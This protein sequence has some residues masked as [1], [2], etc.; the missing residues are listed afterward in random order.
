MQVSAV[1]SLAPSTLSHLP[2]EPE[3]KCGPGALPGFK[4]IKVSTLPSLTPSTL[5][6]L[7][8]E[9]ERKCGPGALPG[10]KQIKI[11]KLPSLTPSTL[12]HLPQEPERQCGPGALP[13]FKQIEVSKLPSFVAHFLF[14]RNIL[15][16]MRKKGITYHSGEAFRK[17]IE[18]RDGT[19]RRVNT[20]KT[21]KKCLTI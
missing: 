3:R 21:V 10:F 19:T 4:Q 17:Y 14:R 5:S 1:F 2:Q 9:P 12:S 20:S 15:V 13:G 16:R 8:Q 6:H 11:R 7:P 18:K